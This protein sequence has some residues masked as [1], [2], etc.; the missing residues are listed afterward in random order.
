MDCSI[1]NS[2]VEIA[3][4]TYVSP[5][6]RLQVNIVKTGVDIEN[7]KVSLSGDFVSEIYNLLLSFLQSTIK[8]QIE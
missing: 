1:G 3:A 2:R 5:E 7:F 8:S 6:K 4:E